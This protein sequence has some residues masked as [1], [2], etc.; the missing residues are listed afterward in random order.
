MKLLRLSLAVV[1]LLQAAA[2]Q[3]ADRVPADEAYR[4]GVECFETGQ[5]T[6]AEQQFQRAVV[7]RPKWASGWKALGTVYAA[8]GRH[9][10]AQE[11]FLK[12]CEL[13]RREPDAC[14]Y[15]A[16]NH[17]LLNQFDEALERF[18]SLLGDDPQP[19][20]IHNGIGL[21][22]EG[23]GR[24]GEAER[25][26]GRAIERE[27]GRASPNEDPRINL[28]NLLLRSGR[29]E[30]SLAVLERAVA[31]KPNSP[32]AHFELGKLLQQQ[33][34]NE[35]SRDHLERALELDPR[36]SGTHALLG[37]VYYRLGDAQRGAR[38]TRQAR[39]ALGG[40][41]NPGLRP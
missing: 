1:G 26:F 13:D 15:L 35:E 21:A 6:C 4:G 8:T 23:L 40:Q 27:R 29:I 24:I 33:N 3:E 38:H 12:A 30:D 19:W 31:A 36:H 22:L 32:R 37:K 7:L 39:E 2:P 10:K 9:L 11:P 16:R 18:R 34:R 28:G 5:M 41:G 25:A 17:Y 14:Y 20:R